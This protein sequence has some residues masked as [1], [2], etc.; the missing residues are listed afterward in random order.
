M[1]TY[2]EA[3]QIIDRHAKP[4]PAKRVHIGQAR[5]RFLAED[6]IARYD[7]PPFDNSAVDGFGRSLHDLDSTR[8]KV[9]AKLK[10]GDKGTVQVGR[11][12]AVRIFTGAPV[13]KDIAAVSMQEDCETD[14]DFVIFKEPSELGDHIRRTG[15]DFQKGDTVLRT[16]A[17]MSP[18]AVGIA[19][20][21]GFRDVSVTPNPEVSMLTSG[22]ELVN[23]THELPPWKIYDSNFY[24]LSSAVHELLD[25]WTITTASDKPV[26]LRRK[27]LDAMQGDIV[28]TTGGVSVGEHDLL[29]EEFAHWNVKE[30][31]WRVA[32][33]PGKPVY[34]GTQGDKL[35]FGLP[36]NP[37]SA[38]VTYYLFAK[39]AILK[40]MGH[41]DPWPNPLRARFEGECRKKPGRMEFLRGVLSQEGTENVAREAGEQGSHQMA[42]MAASNCLIH[43]PLE[44]SELHNGDEVEVTHLAWGLT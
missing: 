25:D 35:V 6:L 42:A 17:Y 11:G 12:Q 41:P 22:T 3:I 1:I 44:A 13:P 21:A 39:P 4:L 32:I 20:S 37:V 10:A 8:L 18:A 27:M 33:K 40:R 2:E 15:G 9:V 24:A 26:V 5:G 30:R 43:F 23:I 7:S 36:G 29:K 14:G 16:G 19:I 38:L 31:F 28:I 34:F